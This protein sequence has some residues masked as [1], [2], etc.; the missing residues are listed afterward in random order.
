MF[1]HDILADKLK[2]C[3]S[4]HYGMM[5]LKIAVAADDTHDIEVY[6]RAAVYHLEYFWVL[7]DESLSG[8]ILN[9]VRNKIKSA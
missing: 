6:F 4:D 3:M 8:H 2:E 1:Q 7:G 9:L 5:M